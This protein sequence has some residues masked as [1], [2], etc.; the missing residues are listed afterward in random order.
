MGAQGGDAYLGALRWRRVPR[1]RRGR[2]RDEGRHAHVGV[3]VVAVLALVLPVRA[4]V[5]GACTLLLREEEVHR[6]LQVAARAL[7]EELG[8]L[9]RTLAAGELDEHRDLLS[10]IHVKILYDLRARAVRR[11]NSA[12]GQRLRPEG[13]F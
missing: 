7:Q 6:K 10:R 8:L 11:G 2:H 4:F 13:A 12:L 1:G 3:L 9:G 5:H